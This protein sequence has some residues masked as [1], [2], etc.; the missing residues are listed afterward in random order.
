[1]KK[2]LEQVKQCHKAFGGEVNE[3]PVKNI[4]QNLKNLRSGLINEEAKEAVDAIQKENLEDIAKELADL[5][6]VTY[7]T[8]VSLG[9]SEKFEEIFD[10]VHRS[11][12][13]K[14][15]KDEDG[16]FLKGPDYVPADIKEILY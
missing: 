6:Y 7:G 15:G 9:L 5:L 11:N 16:K 8:I 14:L 10:E 3:L 4:S 12:M 2:Q 1:M 13:S